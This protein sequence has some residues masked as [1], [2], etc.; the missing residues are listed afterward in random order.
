MAYKTIK[1]GEFDVTAEP[2]PFSMSVEALEGAGKTHFGLIGTPGPV[3]HI[4][5]GDRDAT[6]FLYQMDEKRRAEIT[7]YDF[8]AP[9][10]AGW[11]RAEGM[12]SLKDL[13]AIAKDHLSDGKMAGGTFI[14]DSGSSWWETVQECY[15]KPQTEARGDGKKVGG[16]EYMQGNLIVSGVVSWLKSQGV[17][18]IITHRKRQDWGANGPIPNSYS[19]QINRK[20]PYLVEVRLDLYKTCNGN[21]TTPCGSQECRAPGHIGRTHKGRFLKFAAATALEGMEL[22]PDKCNFGTVYQMYTGK[23]PPWYP[24]E[25]TKA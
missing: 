21:G 16:L 10:S 1:G 17:F 8:Q 19:P 2:A 15:V 9:S 13:S 11:S 3:V 20:I 22:A 5:Y 18:V 23:R 7:M 24:A 14:L 6:I 25:E 4:N 12:E